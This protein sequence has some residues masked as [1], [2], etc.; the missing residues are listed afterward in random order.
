MSRVKKA[1]KIDEFAEVLFR[2]GH[3][4]NDPIEFEKMFKRYVK[5]KGYNIKGF[6]NDVKVT[7][8]EGGASFT[9]REIK[10]GNVK[11]LELD[12]VTGDYKVCPDKWDTPPTKS[13]RQPTQ[14]ATQQAKEPFK[15][16]YV[17]MGGDE[18]SLFAYN[19]KDEPEQAYSYDDYT[20]PSRAYD[21]NE[22]VELD[23]TSSSS[24]S[25]ILSALFIIVLA[26]RLIMAFFTKDAPSTEF[27]AWYIALATTKGM[28][29]D[30]KNIHIAGR[31]FFIVIV[32]LAASN[33]I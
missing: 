31:I 4:T 13:R 8:V 6:N 30:G 21:P 23:F 16:D 3:R 12:P 11:N 5:D 22:K 19:E 33:F 32:W 14:Q 20:E 24:I 17:G 15:G 29:M 1:D 26:V 18:H 10:N 28:I 2:K 25:A 9:Q 7:T 27:W